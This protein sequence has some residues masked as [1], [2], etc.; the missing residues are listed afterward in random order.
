VPRANRH[1]LPG[2]VWHLT[3]RCHERKFLLKFGRDRRAWIDW[4][5]EART[6]Y[7]LCVLNYTATSN[8]SH[9]LAWDQGHGEIASSMQLIAGCTGQDYNRRKARRGAF[10]EDRYHATAVESGEHLA[11]RLVYI[12]LNMVRAGVVSHPAQWPAGGYHEIQA[13]PRRYRIVDRAALAALLGLESV[14]ELPRVHAEWV[15]TAL[16]NREH[17]RQPQWTESLAV[18]SRAFAERVSSELGDRARYREVGAVDDA[19][20]LREPEA[21]YGASFAGENGRIS[22]E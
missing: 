8:H 18:G 1:Y 4:L 15:E 7:G 17:H 9:L 3:H 5:Y 6:R 22:P 16:Q 10:W 19:F 13:A 11:R 20:V 2:Y 14:S 12:D 21:S